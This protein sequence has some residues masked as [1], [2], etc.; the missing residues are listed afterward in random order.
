VE[1]DRVAKLPQNFEAK[2]DRAEY[3]LGEIDRKREIEDAG[4]FILTNR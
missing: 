1:E 3:V 2:K 4:K